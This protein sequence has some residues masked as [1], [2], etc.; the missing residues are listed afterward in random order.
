M[1]AACYIRNWINTLSFLSGLLR[2]SCSYCRI[3]KGCFAAC[4]WR[5]STPKPTSDQIFTVSSETRASTTCSHTGDVML[6]HRWC[7][8]HTQV[9]LLGLSEWLTIDGF[10]GAFYHGNWRALHHHAACWLVNIRITWP[11]ALQ[12]P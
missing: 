10:H 2:S 5:C 6:T 11:F 8:A 12:L 1:S 9:M 7:H 4:V 3:S